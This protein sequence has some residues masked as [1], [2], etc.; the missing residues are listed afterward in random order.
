M[1]IRDWNRKEIIGM[2]YKSNET[3]KM[4]G[5]LCNM[6]QSR[7]GDRVEGFVIL[8]VIDDPNWR[9][10]SIEFEAYKYFPIRLNYDRGRFGCS[11]DYGEYGIS[12]E[13]S[14]KW[15]DTADFDIFFDDLERELELRIP[16]KFLKARGW[17]KKPK[18]WFKD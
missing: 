13:S 17:Y 1:V 14:Q 15:W 10:F 8:R 18:G 16:D 5:K 7:F 12:L 3:N 2:Q 4:A 6:L 9:E 11:I